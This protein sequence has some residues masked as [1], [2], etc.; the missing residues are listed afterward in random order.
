[1]PLEVFEL[2]LQLL[3]RIAR[4]RDHFSLRTTDPATRPESLRAKTGRDEIAST[5]PD[6]AR[7]ARAIR[8]LS[9]AINLSAA[10]RV[11]FQDERPWALRAPDYGGG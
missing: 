6:V 8:I 3:E 10:G 11:P 5:Y 4:N 7:V 9:Q 1:M 2:L